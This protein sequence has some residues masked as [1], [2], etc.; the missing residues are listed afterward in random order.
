MNNKKKVSNRAKSVVIASA[1][2][3]VATLTTCSAL[4]AH[5]ENM[6]KLRFNY[7]QEN[8]EMMKPLLRDAENQ[9]KINIEVAKK[10]QENEKIVKK[11][12]EE[13]KKK[14]EKLNT[15]LEQL[16]KQTGLNIISF[17]EYTFELSFYSDLNCENGYGTLTA[18]GENLSAGMIANNFLPF[19][20]M[21]YFEGY[22]TKRVT[23]RGS[24]EYFNAV[25][26][27]DVFVP[28]NSGE[29]DGEYYDRVNNMGRKYVT[30]YIL[31]IGD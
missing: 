2:A 6:N 24:E 27:A 31:E 30:G 14:K 3:T 19:N 10:V 21:V 8:V 13:E 20:T 26:K 12:R 17:R 4:E 16:K 25:N 1:I 7:E 15:K 9:A 11:F 18:N 29:S 28:R 23:D 5:S 22:G